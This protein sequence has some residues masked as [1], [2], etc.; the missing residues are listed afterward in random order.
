M[1]SSL[2][3]KDRP[4]YGMACAL[5]AFLLFA[6]MNAMAK[7]LAETH[8]VIEIGFYRNLFASI[9]ILIWVY[10]MNN[11]HILTIHSKPGGIIARSVI[12]TLS[13][14]V[15]F[16]AFAA[17]PFAD[18]TAF[19]FTSSLIV[20]MFAFFFLGERVGPYRW[21]AI[22]IG[23]VGVLIMV[24]PTGEVNTLGI[25]LALS[26]ALMHATLQTI[27]RA[28][29][30]TESPETVTFYFVFIGMFVSLIPMP[31]V[32]TMP[33][34]QELPLMIGVGLSGLGAQLL[35]SRAYKYAQVS[36]V[37]VFNYSGIIWAMLIG[38]LFWDEW[39]TSVI[40]TGASIVIASNIF[41][42]YREHRLAKIARIKER[43]PDVI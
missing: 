24:Q 33:T 13:L 36:L 35:L 22:L 32:F 27:V 2:P 30:K 14:I 3:H 26:A 25:G 7:M 42:L 15:T 6:V 28:L 34:W 20:P 39:P 5:G 29:G 23:F 8:H 12:G 40:L 9:P 16:A 4:L 37:T 10:G 17:M 11:R 31:F 18:T 41:I 21:G 43:E 19:L 38:W 1:S